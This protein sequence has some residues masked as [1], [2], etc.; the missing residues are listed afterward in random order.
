MY[1]LAILL[2]QNLSVSVASKIPGM[3]SYQLGVA[4]AM[5]CIPV[6]I[7]FG[8]LYMQSHSILCNMLVNLVRYRNIAKIVAV[9]VISK[10]PQ[11]Q[12]CDVHISPWN[13]CSGYPPQDNA[14]SLLVD[15]VFRYLG[16]YS[17]KMEENGNFCLFFS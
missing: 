3:H 1:A 6:L 2:T 13:T 4:Y 8:H 11:T 17:N 9:L 10:N 14:W 7:D 5:I 12:M 16:I 15:I